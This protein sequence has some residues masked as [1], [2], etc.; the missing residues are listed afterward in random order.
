MHHA[1]EGAAGVRRLDIEAGPLDAILCEVVQ[2]ADAVDGKS[3]SCDIASRPF[4]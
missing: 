1:V 3:V 2:Q 4:R